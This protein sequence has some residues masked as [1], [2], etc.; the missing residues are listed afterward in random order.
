MKGLLLTLS[1]LFFAVPASSLTFYE[2]NVELSS[3]IMNM[4]V[5]ASTLS[6]DAHYVFTNKGS[7]TQ[8]ISLSFPGY[9][10][11]TSITSEGK[12]TNEVTLAPGASVSVNAHDV[13]ALNSSSSFSFDP[14]PLVNMLALSAPTQRIV[15][16]LDFPSS[17]TLTSSSFPFSDHGITGAY[18]SYR[19]D[20][21]QAYPRLIFARW[22][23][24]APS[25]SLSRTASAF[26]H[27]GDTVTIVSHIRNTGTTTLTNL[28]V[29]DSLLTTH[30][31]PITPLEQFTLTDSPLEPVSTFTASI[32][33]LASGE[34][35]VLTYQA[36]VHTLVNL[37]LLPLRVYQNDL[38]VASLP[39]ESL[40]LSPMAFSPPNP[41]AL[42]INGSFPEPVMTLLA[43]DTPIIP[44]G[45]EPREEPTSFPSWILRTIILTLAI[46]VLFVG[47]VLFKNIRKITTSSPRP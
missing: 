44:A 24:D 12:E 38:F 23:I 45:Q 7:T 22:L 9:F 21:T 5:D 19:S 47:I 36:S 10:S 27:V 26:H 20:R 11:G 2:G 18:H 35:H 1:L 6:V 42:V 17:A 43:I 41:D 28:K 34:E 4:H 31:K 30:F 39:G 46:A 37:R 25:L 33:S 3:L 13:Q 29:T 32:P 15:T 40:T 14:A 16:V 8:T